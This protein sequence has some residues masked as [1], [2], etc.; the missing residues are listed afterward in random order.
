M[1]DRMRRKH[2]KDFLMGILKGFDKKFP[3]ILTYYIHMRIPG[4]TEEDV[5]E[6]K[7][8]ME[9]VHLINSG[10]SLILKNGNKSCAYGP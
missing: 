7:S 10:A 4:E 8:V 9:A 3:F 6:I 2:D 5:T 1:L